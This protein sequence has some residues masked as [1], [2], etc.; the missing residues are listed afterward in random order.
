RPRYLPRWP[1]PATRD[2]LPGL[3]HH[4]SPVSRCKNTC[5][6]LAG[7]AS[8]QPKT[9]FYLTLQD[10]AHFLGSMVRKYILHAVQIHHHVATFACLEY[11]TL[12][13]EPA[14]ELAV[15]HDAVLGIPSSMIQQKC[16]A[17]SPIL[18]C[19]PHLVPVHRWWEPCTTLMFN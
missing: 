11:H 17:N 15:F 4:P 14:F 16:C 3:S 5:C 6:S 12:L 7:L 8:G 19:R 9:P 2:R 1:L 18:R 13:F 10:L